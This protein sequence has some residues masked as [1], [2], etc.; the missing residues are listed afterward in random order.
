M[1]LL[2]LENFST[3]TLTIKL[4]S[5]SFVKAKTV[6][7]SSILASLKT[8]S[9]SPLPLMTREL[10]SSF[11]IYS[12]LS[13]FFSIIF[14]LVPSKLVSNNL[15]KFKPIFPPPIIAFANIGDTPKSSGFNTLSLFLPK[16]FVGPVKD[17]SSYPSKAYR[18]VKLIFVS[19]NDCNFLV[20]IYL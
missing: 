6:S 19:W 7:E 1:V 13:L 18:I 2:S 20:Y 9:S 12:A 8:S 11:A 17:I 5:S 4:S 16:T 10:F 14:I 3:K 15:A